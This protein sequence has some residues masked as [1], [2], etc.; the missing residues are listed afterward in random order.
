MQ[1]STG[2]KFKLLAT[3]ALTFAAPGAALAVTIPFSQSLAAIHD[4]ALDPSV[5]GGDYFATNGQV[6]INPPG[7]TSGNVSGSGDWGNAAAMASADLTTGQ[8]RG[9]V[10]GNLTGVGVY[11]YNTIY[12][13]TNAVFGDGFRAYDLSGTPF[14]WQ[15]GTTARFGITVDG[16]LF[17]SPSLQAINAGAWVTLFLFQH[18]TMTPDTI[19]GVQPNMIGYY[20]FLI[21]NPNLQVTSFGSQP[22]S[23]D[24]LQLLP[25]QYVGDLSSGPI[26]IVQD[27]TPGGDFDWALLLG[28]YSFANNPGDQFNLDLSH[29]VTFGYQGPEG[30]VTRSTS[31][32]FDNY[33]VPTTSVPEPGTLALLAIGLLGLGFSRSKARAIR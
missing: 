3:A 10:S 25:T 7:A 28:A 9:A 8:L 6:A 19:F 2:L 13:Q 26:N 29:T 31:G 5:P 18:D 23:A 17:S 14:S 22:G 16:S 12:S 1:V 21:G 15:S 33:N 27:F 4:P 32:L 11:N 24:D 30:S 20:H